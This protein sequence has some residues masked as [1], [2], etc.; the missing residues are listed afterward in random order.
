MILTVDYLPQLWCGIST[1]D[2]LQ[3]DLEDE[4]SPQQFRARGALQNN[5]EFA[6]AFRCPPGSPMNPRTRCIIF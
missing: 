5:E 4:H 1:K 3:A 6:R 2:S